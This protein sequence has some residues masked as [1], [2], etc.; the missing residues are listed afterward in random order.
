MQGGTRLLNSTAIATALV[1]GSAAVGVATQ[2]KRPLNIEVQRGRNRSSMGTCEETKATRNSSV[3]A[4]AGLCQTQQRPSTEARY[5]KR[6]IKALLGATDTLRR[7][8]QAF[9][10][11]NEP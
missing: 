2:H 4:S 6:N 9:D 1:E 10:V 3:P 11:F 5:R 8:Y 7:Q